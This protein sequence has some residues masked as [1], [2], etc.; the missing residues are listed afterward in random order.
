ME[1]HTGP[2]QVVPVYDGAIDLGTSDL[3]EY[4]RTRET[5]HLRYRD[6]ETPVVFHCR[7]L[8]L[9]ER[10]AARSCATDADRYEHAFRS[11]VQ[12][13]DHL[14]WADGSRR[15]WI[16]ASDDG[17]KQRPI[18]D[19][20]LEQHF[21]ESDVQEV[22]SVIWVRSFFSRTAQPYYPLLPTSQHGLQGT[23]A[24]RAAQIVATSSSAK[25]SA[26]AKEP[27]PT[28]P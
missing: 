6:G 28:T 4:L 12:R 15:A 8:T 24:H 26:E 22:G 13:V 23:I 2:F 16:R 21:A 17:A 18:D 1:Q 10:R 9:T 7:V 19:A 27:P 14:Q 5:K 11:C 3:S 20:S 25:S